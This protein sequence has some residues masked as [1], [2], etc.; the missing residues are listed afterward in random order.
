MTRA[1]APVHARIALAFDFDETLGPSTYPEVLRRC[2]YDDPD[3]FVAERV[4]PLVRERDWQTPLART[5]ALIEAL[6]ADGRRLHEADLAELG[7]DYP[8]YDGVAEMFDRVRERARRAA[9]DIDVRFYLITAGFAEV[10]ENTPIAREFDAVYGGAWA[11]DAERGL[12]GAKRLLTDYQKVGYLMMIAKGFELGGPIPADIWRPIDP[13]DWFVPLDQMVF[14]G[15]GSSDMPA[16]GLMGEH[17]GIGLGVRH[18]RGPDSWEHADEAHPRRQVESVGPADYTEGSET[19]ESLL[20][21]TDVVASRVA[22]R[23]LGGD[24]H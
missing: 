12:V 9:H 6:A 18:R 13:A 17:G 7:R 22:L 10:P 5:H 14:V 21:A 20:L 19:L 2:G 24:G 11:F 15:D 23:R 8:L 1:T 3:A 16:F 4:E